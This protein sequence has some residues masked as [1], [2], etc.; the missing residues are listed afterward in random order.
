MKDF[1]LDNHILQWA[2]NQS[3]MIVYGHFLALASNESDLNALES[4]TYEG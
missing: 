1:A 2:Y 3:F 4:Q